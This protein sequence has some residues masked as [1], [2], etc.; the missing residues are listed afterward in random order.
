MMLEMVSDCDKCELRSKCNQVIAGHGPEDAK[1]MVVGEYPGSEEDL[2]GE[3]FVGRDGLLISKL[4]KQ[5][6]FEKYY[7]TLAVKCESRTAPP[8][9]SIQACKS[10]LR[11]EV[12]S[13]RPK[14]I[15]ALGKT[16][17][18]LLLNLKKSLKLSDYLGKVHAVNYTSAKI[19]VWHSSQL[20]LKS[21]QKSD[22]ETVRF[23]T[24]LKELI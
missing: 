9:A 18:R 2:L 10:W 20:L 17:T 4:L 6:G 19:A 21:G 3:P 11:Q 7:K 12:E 23:L 13:L 5:A 8:E 24:S 1:L 22:I 14:V 15:L 16:P